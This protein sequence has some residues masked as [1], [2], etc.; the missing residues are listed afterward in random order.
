MDYKPNEQ[1][2]SI[3]AHIIIHSTAC[4]QHLITAAACSS[5]RKLRIV[6]Q[7]HKSEK[8]A[9]NN[10]DL[11]FGKFGLEGSSTISSLVLVTGRQILNFNVLFSLLDSEG[12]RGSPSALGLM[13]LVNPCCKQRRSLVLKQREGR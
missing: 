5:I 10:K 6:L 2:L 12:T 3:H 7:L 1:G 9:H 4:C 11:T 8:K 13:H